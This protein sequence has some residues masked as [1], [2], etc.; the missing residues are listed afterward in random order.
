MTAPALFDIIPMP[1]GPDGKADLEALPPPEA[2]YY[3][4]AADHLLIHKRTHYGR[5]LVPVPNA[6][7]LPEVGKQTSFLWHH[8]PKLPPTLLG[9]VWSFFRAVWDELHTEAMIYLTWHPDHGYRVFVPPQ[10]VSGAH[11]DA[12]W[13]PTHMTNG[14]S[15]VGSIH[16]HCDFTAGHSSTDT[17]DA[18]GHDGLHITIGKVNKDPAEWAVMIS[19]NKQRWDFALGDITTDAPQI[20]PHPRWWHRY[21]TKGSPPNRQIQTIH[22]TPTGSMV[23]LWLQAHQAP[24]KTATAKPTPPRYDPMAAWLN[25]NTDEDDLIL[26]EAQTLATLTDL[27]FRDRAE[28]LNE[29]A[30][31]QDDLLH[32]I[33]RLR[34][35]GIDITYT[36][37]TFPITTN[38]AATP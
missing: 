29:A 3:V 10:H 7:H 38:E 1:T 5:A 34:E 20:I 30:W 31:L 4:L 2:P 28:F 27:D 33:T 19:I 9:Q 25:T 8:I 16:S 17:G 22:G 21:L 35:L 13:N 14:W 11:V 26:T 15:N 6:P 37:D 23:P 32:T 36:V 12:Q 24:T 18:D